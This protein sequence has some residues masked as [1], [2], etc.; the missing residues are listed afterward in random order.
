MPKPTGP[1]NTEMRKLIDEVRVKGFK[2]KSDFLIMLAKK[3]ET[4]ERRR[5]E[6]NIGTIDRNCS[7]GEINGSIS[8]V[9]SEDVYQVNITDDYC[10]N[11]GSV[12]INIGNILIKNITFENYFCA[13]YNETSIC[14]DSKIDGNG[15]GVCL[16]G[17][18]RKYLEFGFNG[19]I[20]R[21]INSGGDEIIIT[22][23]FGEYSKTVKKDKTVVI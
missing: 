2:D 3:L 17:E 9:C 12:Q 7:D 13:K 20:E 14:C 19:Y 5:P 10:E 6:V 1:T 4:P 18:T 23:A 8:M 22:Q 21:T 16:S 15:D 11:N